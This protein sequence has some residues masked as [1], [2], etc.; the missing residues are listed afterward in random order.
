MNIYYVYAYP[1]K[2][3]SPYYIGK[4][5]ALRAWK[6]CTNDTIQP[7]VDHSRI[8]ILESNL[9]EVGAFA[10]ERR[11]IG[12]YGRIDT[13]TGILRNKTEGG[14]GASGVIRKRVVC[15]V[16]GKDSDPGNFTRFHGRNCTGSRN[17]KPVPKGLLT[18]PH[19]GFECRP[20]NYQKYHG[21]QCWK[22]PNSV[23][24]GQV[25]RRIKRER[26]NNQYQTPTT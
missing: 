3:G 13:N 11:M 18:C 26:R 5:K 1:R 16:C 21:N 23:R 10:L 12:W 22:N 25:P 4:G 14:E 15:E 7:P 9:S 8:V 17:Q 6:H 19:C 24:Y 2:D 20:C